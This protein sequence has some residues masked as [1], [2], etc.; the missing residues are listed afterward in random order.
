MADLSKLMTGQNGLA[1]SP[2][3]LQPAASRSSEAKIKE[4]AEGFESVLIRQML[5]E[6]RGT[7][8]DKDK[9]SLNTGYLDIGDDHLANHLVK[10]GG[11]GFA[12]AMADQMLS[13]IKTAELIGSK[14]KAVNP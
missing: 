7:S 14:Q 9:S 1:L 3:A 12:K 5:R 11:L 4:A 8:L 6:L 13:Q 2:L 10:A